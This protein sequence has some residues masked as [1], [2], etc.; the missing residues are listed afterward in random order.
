M[1]KKENANENLA[2]L[3]AEYVRKLH[4]IQFL[5]DKYKPL[6]DIAVDFDKKLE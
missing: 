1:F 4:M 5:G 3:H 6:K 2:V